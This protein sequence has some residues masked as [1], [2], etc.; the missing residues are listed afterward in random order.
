MEIEVLQPLATRAQAWEV[1]P[2]ISSWVL[3]TIKH[4]FTA[5]TSLCCRRMVASGPSSIS[6]IWTNLLRCWHWN[7]SMS[8]GKYFISKYASITDH[9]WESCSRGWFTVLPFGLSLTPCTFTK[10]MDASIS[11]LRQN[12]VWIPNY[13]EHWFVLAH[14]EAESNTYR[15]LQNAW[16]SGTT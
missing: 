2:G 13:P 15:S 8:Q 12:G 5:I 7:M 1:I 9:F 11:S 4:A 3:N 6:G 16:I 10:C 14:L